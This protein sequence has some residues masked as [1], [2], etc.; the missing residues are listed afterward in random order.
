MRLFSFT[1]RRGCGNR[2]RGRWDVEA[3][4]HVSRARPLLPRARV[5]SYLGI[6]RAWPPHRAASC[7][8]PL[9]QTPTIR[10]DSQQVHH[11]RLGRERHKTLTQSNSAAF[12]CG[13][14]ESV[15]DSRSTTQSTDHGSLCYSAVFPIGKLNSGIFHLHRSNRHI[16]HACGQ[17]SPCLS[18][19][20]PNEY[21]CFPVFAAIATR[22][23]AWVARRLRAGKVKV[24]WRNAQRSSSRGT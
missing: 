5:P 3:K 14:W 20:L 13:C 16:E 19:W 17:N 4:R 7:A 15:S 1:I 24:G 18:M 12:A 8:T 11:P 6:S 2:V 9:N 21:L 23:R 10:L 22:R